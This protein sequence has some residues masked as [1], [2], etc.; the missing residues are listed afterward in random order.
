MAQ[1]TG[2]SEERIRQLIRNCQIKRAIKLGGWLVKAEDF[3]AFLRSRSYEMPGDKTD[4][5]GS[6]GNG[7]HPNNGDSTGP[8]N[9]N[10]GEK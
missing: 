10:R 4:G 8:D 5:N 3:Q 1:Q 7:P 9:G 6:H 2:L